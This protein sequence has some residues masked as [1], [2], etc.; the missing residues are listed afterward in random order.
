MYKTHKV[1]I[2]PIFSLVS[3]LSRV[4]TSPII[5]LYP[6]KPSRQQQHEKEQEG[7]YQEEE[8]IMI[9]VPNFFHVYYFVLLFSN[10]LKTVR[11]LES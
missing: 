9:Y 3:N 7:K 11:F 8:G 4:I 2:T 1:N 5:I 6:W 10:L